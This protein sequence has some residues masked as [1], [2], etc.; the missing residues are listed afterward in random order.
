MEDKKGLLAAVRKSIEFDKYLLCSDHVK[1]IPLV[2]RLIAYYLVG[3]LM[4]FRPR[5]EPIAKEPCDILFL[6]ISDIHKQREKSIAAHLR[7][8]GY[9]CR[10]LVIPRLKEIFLD[11][12]YLDA[13]QV[14]FQYS[15]FMGFAKFIEEKFSPKIIVTF[16]ENSKFV[17][18]FKFCLQDKGALI[19]IAHAIPDLRHKMLDF[20][21]FFLFG[22]SSLR[23]FLGKKDY[24]IGNPKIV[25]T[26][27]FLLETGNK[28]F[29]PE[30]TKEKGLLFPSFFLSPLDPFNAFDLFDSL[31]V[32]AK[33]NPH[34]KV[35]IKPHPLENHSYWQD[36]AKKIENIIV[37]PKEMKLNEIIERYNIFLLITSHSNISIEVAA[38]GIPSVVL[39]PW[40]V[41]DSYLNLEVFFGK[42]CTNPQELSQRI[43]DI[44]NRYHEYL[45][46]AKRYAKF[47]LEYKTETL[48]IIQSH[49]EKIFKGQP[50]SG[51]VFTVEGLQ[52]DEKMAASLLQQS[53][54][55]QNHAVF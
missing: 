28:Q 51:Q 13:N 9:H 3:I 34:R 17:P 24:I 10:C 21:Y 44:E 22:K 11:K 20:D 5:V 30:L 47:H 54:I 2:F 14:P 23:K 7:Q 12:I 1:K 35:F 8:K 53:L 46:Q 33:L 45:E 42:K 25:L 29:L 49:V 36:N 55:P 15:L 31:C 27:S 18:F 50:L 19:N 38:M 4:R 6:Y 39:N 16:S 52:K 41:D 43:E 48:D 26:G 40:S 37:L 32:W